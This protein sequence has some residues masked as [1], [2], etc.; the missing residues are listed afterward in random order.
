MALY[1]ASLEW[2]GSREICSVKAKK[3]CMEDGF[4]DGGIPSHPQ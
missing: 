1:H 2:W 3:K 4:M